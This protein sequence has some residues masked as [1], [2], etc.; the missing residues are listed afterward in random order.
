MVYTNIL[1]TN[2]R[3]LVIFS[4]LIFSLLAIETIE[5]SL[6]FPSFSFF[7]FGKTL[8]VKQDLTV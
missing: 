5:K 3:N 8:L 1:K 6:H 4:Y 2:Y 7:L